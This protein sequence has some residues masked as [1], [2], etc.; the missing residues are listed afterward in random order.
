MI[1]HETIRSFGSIIPSKRQT[2]RQ[3]DRQHDLFPLLSSTVIRR[4]EID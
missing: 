3:A 2:N 4:K 1:R